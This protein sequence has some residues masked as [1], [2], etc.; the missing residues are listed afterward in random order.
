MIRLKI[1]KPSHRPPGQPAVQEAPEPS[2]VRAS[3]KP[4]EKR[5]AG[6]SDHVAK[7]SYKLLVPMEGQGYTQ[8]V[9]QNGYGLFL[10]N[11][12]PPGATIEL[13]FNE[14]QQGTRP[15][16]P[17]AKVVWQKEHQAGV[18]LLGK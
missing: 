16:K 9:S 15:D 14:T 18:K 12:V 3:K 6:R 7:F 5:Q 11:E 1:Y 8:N 13:Q 4:A 2:I 10:D 17:I